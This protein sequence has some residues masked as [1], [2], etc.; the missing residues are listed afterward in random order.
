MTPWD[1]LPESI[2][3]NWKIDPGRVLAAENR[4]RGSMVQWVAKTDSHRYTW[5]F[6]R[7]RQ[8]WTVRKTPL[9]KTS[10]D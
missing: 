7:S 6:V 5:T 4:S 2:R 8:Q 9:F 1:S 10:G 3:D